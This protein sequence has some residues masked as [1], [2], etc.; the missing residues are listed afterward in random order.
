MFK[1]I[2][3]RIRKQTISIAGISIFS[4]LI[5]LAVSCKK[6]STVETPTSS[7]IQF[8]YSSDAHFGI[9]RPT[10]QGAINVNSSV[11]NAKLVEKINSL[12]ALTIPADNGVNAGKVVS[13][14]DT[15]VTSQIVRKAHLP[16]K[17]LQSPGG[18]LAQLTSTG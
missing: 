5:F 10:F 7:V 6:D 2:N 16:F 15:R 8:V 1:K 18:N 14:I 3:N 9:T 17:V 11:V 13:G 4:L 12:P